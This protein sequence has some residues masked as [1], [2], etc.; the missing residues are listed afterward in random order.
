M[1]LWGDDMGKAKMLWIGAI[2]TPGK[3]VLTESAVRSV[4]SS[5]KSCAMVAVGFGISGTDSKAGGPDY[6]LLFTQAKS[7]TVK[8]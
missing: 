5:V 3:Q 7:I 8:V 6:M 1:L 2:L 4:P